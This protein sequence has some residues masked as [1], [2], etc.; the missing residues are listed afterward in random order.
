VNGVELAWDEWGA[1]GA[2]PQFVLCHGFIGS[3]FD[4]ALQIETLAADRPVV[5]VDHRGHGASTKTH[6]AASYS[7]EQLV[8]DFVAFLQHATRPPVDLLGHSMGG[9]IVLGTVLEHPEL[10]RS[11]I[12]MDT[13]AG[14]FQ[15]DDPKVREM[16]SAFIASYDPAAGMPDPNLM[17]GPEDDLAEVTTPQSWRDRKL[18]LFEGTDPYLLKAIGTELFTSSALSVWDRLGEITC[19]VTVLVGENDH[20]FVDR[21]PELAADLPNGR[22][23]VID[24]AYHSPQLT[25]SDEWLAAVAEHL[26]RP[27]S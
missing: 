23:V 3:S 18:E 13:T 20:P 2:D 8:E 12:L 27:L 14:S 1:G 11:L 7:V 5:A 19:P 4:F 16:M 6:D 21:A 10:V 25:H 9:R 15:P 17:R 26:A 22:L 24:G